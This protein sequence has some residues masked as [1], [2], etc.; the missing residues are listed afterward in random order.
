M[1]DGERSGAEI[2]EQSQHYSCDA[3]SLASLD[4]PDLGS[5]LMSMAKLRL[6]ASPTRSWR[7]HP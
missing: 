1:R 4:N 5:G 6:V 3:G 7:P 2:I